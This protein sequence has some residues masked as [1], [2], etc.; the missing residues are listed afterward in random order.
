MNELVINLIQTIICSGVFYLFYKWAIS[1]ETFFAFNRFYLLASMLLSIAFG[2]SDINLQEVAASSA[3]ISMVL[4]VVEVLPKAN[5]TGSLL[6]IEWGSA[7][8]YIY[9]SVSAGLLVSFLVRIAKLWWL[10]RKS[11][12]YVQD[13][14]TIVVIPDSHS[15]FS[16]FHHIYIPNSMRSDAEYE[17]IFRHERA[18]ADQ[19]HTL[20][21][22]FIELLQIVFW[23]NPLVYSYKKALKEIHEYLADAVVVKQGYDRAEYQLLIFQNAIGAEVSLANC[24]NQSQIKNRIVMLT[25]KRSDVLSSIKC[26]M[27][28]P[29]A[30]LL[31]FTFASIEPTSAQVENKSQ[32]G[33]NGAY[34]MATVMPTFNGSETG[35]MMYIAQNVVY[36]KDA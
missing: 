30:M 16:F 10:K 33:E 27:A 34:D 7:I 17:R 24:F 8:V 9:L 25:K 31:F 36:P 35:A 32:K 28:L 23:F 26:L 2:F 18:H 15:P 21:I 4:D 11:L 19:W 14:Y 3:A 13:N 20:D 12:R 6:N 29:L 1:G 22:L 5:N